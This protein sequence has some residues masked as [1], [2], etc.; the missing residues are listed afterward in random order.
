MLVCMETGSATIGNHDIYVYTHIYLYVNMYIYVCIYTHMN[1]YVYMY[2]H[3]ICIYIH[4][5]IHIQYIFAR[6][7][8]IP[9]RTLLQ[10]T[11]SAL[12]NHPGQSLCSFRSLFWVSRLLA[13]SWCHRSSHVIIL[14]YIV[15]KYTIVLY[16]VILCHFMLYCILVY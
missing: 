16:Y 7:Y 12:P 2:I 13:R 14:Y 10:Y 4:I 5:H 1:I 6:S 9:K 8:T 15:S 3:I 11:Q